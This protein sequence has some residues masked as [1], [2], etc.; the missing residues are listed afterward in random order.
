MEYKQ[1]KQ[2]SP[3]YEYGEGKEFLT[4]E[5]A[6]RKIKKA[7]NDLKTKM[8]LN[9]LYEISKVEISEEKNSFQLVVTTKIEKLL[10]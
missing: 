2:Y 10:C 4:R 5:D 1:V 7:E 8:A 6:L 9:N 3:L